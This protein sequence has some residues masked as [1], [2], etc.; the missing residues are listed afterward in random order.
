MHT[1]GE[2]DFEI[3]HFRNFRITVTLTLT[4]DLGLAHTAYRRLAL[5]VIYLYTKFRSNQKNRGV[6]LSREPSLYGTGNGTLT[7]HPCNGG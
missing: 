2:T 4:F 1:G 3:G 5:I 7:L 6:D